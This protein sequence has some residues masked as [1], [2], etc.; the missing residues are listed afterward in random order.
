MVFSI[1]MNLLEENEDLRNEFSN[2]EIM[3]AN[4]KIKADAAKKR[5]ASKLRGKPLRGGD[6]PSHIE[7]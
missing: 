3:I 2:S 5:K 4:R 6:T 1:I 7:E